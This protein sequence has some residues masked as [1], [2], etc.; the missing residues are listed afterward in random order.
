MN[1]EKVDLDKLPKDVL[2]T[3]KITDIDKEPGHCISSKRKWKLFI[4]IHFTE[5]MWR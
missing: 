3:S 4:Q 5:S 1:A 2:G